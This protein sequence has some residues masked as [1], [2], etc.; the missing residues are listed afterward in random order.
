MARVTAQS[1]TAVMIITAAELRELMGRLNQ[2]PG[3]PISYRG[4]QKHFDRILATL[5]HHE[6]FPFP[7]SPLLLDVDAFTG[8]HCI[9]EDKDGNVIAVG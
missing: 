2:H 6:G 4:M 8:G 5:E 9:A 7:T 1:K 3:D